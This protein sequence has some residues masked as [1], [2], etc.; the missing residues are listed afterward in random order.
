VKRDISAALR[1]MAGDT[2]RAQPETQGKVTGLEHSD[3]SDSDSEA[4]P[5]KRVGAGGGS[6][7]G[8]GKERGG[9]V[10]KIGEWSIERGRRTRVEGGGLQT[11]H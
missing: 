3:I 9:G 8:A 7:A 10:P 4:A 5:M 2:P 11:A 6:R 1:Y